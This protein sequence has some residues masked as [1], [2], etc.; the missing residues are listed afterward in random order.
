MRPHEPATYFPDV[1]A[2]VNGSRS[3]AICWIAIK[4]SMNGLFN[5]YAMHQ[6]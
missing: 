3:V 1:P 6:G 4:F 2:M 5:V